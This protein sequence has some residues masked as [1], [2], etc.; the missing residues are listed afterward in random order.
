[1][2][3]ARNKISIEK[4]TCFARNYPI[5]LRIYSTELAQMKDNPVGTVSM[6]EL[7]NGWV[8]GI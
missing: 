6:N 4:L 3:F 7:D 1:M 8:F 5:W 2:N